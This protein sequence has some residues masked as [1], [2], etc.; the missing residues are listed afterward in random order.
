[1]MIFGMLGVVAVVSPQHV[2]VLPPAVTAILIGATRTIGVLAAILP[3]MRWSKCRPDERGN[4]PYLA[5]LGCAAIAGIISLLVERG[6]YAIALGDAFAP[7]D[8]TRYPMTPMAP[9]AFATS[10]TLSILCDVDLRLGYGWARRVSE[11]LL[12]SWPPLASTFASTC[13]CSPRHRLRCGSGCPTSSLQGSDSLAAFSLPTYTGALE[14]RN[15][16]RKWRRATP[17]RLTAVCEQPL[18]APPPSR[19][20]MASSP[21]RGEAHGSPVQR[22]RMAAAAHRPSSH[23]GER[24]V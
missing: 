21:I 15:P 14:T 22:N 10:L 13:C 2:Q 12:R 4:P 20:T 5:W 24:P 11:G 18:R 16:P 1:M 7:L 9:M 23:F 3:K 19:A 8:F 17:S 6:A